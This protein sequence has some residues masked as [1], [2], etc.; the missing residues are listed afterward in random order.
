M[1]LISVDFRASHAGHGGAA[2]DQ[3]RGDAGPPG[4][5]PTPGGGRAGGRVLRGLVQVRAL[6]MFSFRMS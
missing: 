4:A 5:G 3:H 1:W 2:A 6:V